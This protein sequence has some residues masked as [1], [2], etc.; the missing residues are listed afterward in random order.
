MR[1]LRHTLRKDKKQLSPA[2]LKEIK[3]KYE[4]I[5]Q[6]GNGKAVEEAPQRSQGISMSGDSQNS[7]RQN[8][9][10]PVLALKLALLGAGG[11][12]RLPTCFYSVILSC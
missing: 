1:L 5:P 4:E 3:I 8:L 9:G 2:A 12:A 10:Q 7:A 11:W 6:N